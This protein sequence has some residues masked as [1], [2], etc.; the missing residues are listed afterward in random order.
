LVPST[1]LEGKG[2]KGA[3]VYSP[4]PHFKF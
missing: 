3:R 4:G 1:I 2:L